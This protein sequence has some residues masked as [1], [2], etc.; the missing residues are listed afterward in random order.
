MCGVFYITSR[1]HILGCYVQFRHRTVEIIQ[2]VKEL[3]SICIAKQNEMPG[4]TA[5][6][7]LSSRIITG[8]VCR[9]KY[10]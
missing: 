1:L 4:F 8:T 7:E 2:T 10:T 6:S 3:D 5:Y 9:E